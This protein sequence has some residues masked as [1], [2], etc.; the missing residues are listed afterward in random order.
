MYVNF[1]VVSGDWLSGIAIWVLQYAL[2]VKRET[3][4]SIYR[5]RT[6]LFVLY[7]SR[8]FETNLNFKWE[9]FNSTFIW[10]G[11]QLKICLKGAII[12]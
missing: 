12:R 8:A 5:S 2:I 7:G 4:L 11:C 10:N 3:D 9:F 6:M 1:C